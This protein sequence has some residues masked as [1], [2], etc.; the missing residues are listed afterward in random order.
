MKRAGD[1]LTRNAKRSRTNTRAWPARVLRPRRLPK[2]EQPVFWTSRRP[3]RGSAFGDGGRRAVPRGSDPAARRPLPKELRLGNRV[4]PLA[5][6]TSLA[7]LLR[8]PEVNYYSLFEMVKDPSAI[9]DDEV[10]Q[11]VEIQIKYQGYI[12]RQHAEVERSRQHE[13]TPLPPDMDY[14]N[15][16]GLS[17]EARQKLSR[18]KPLTLGKPDALGRHAG[19]GVAAAGAPTPARLIRSPMNWRD[20]CISLSH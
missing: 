14:Q 1:G 9:S 19:G 12:E 15:V 6:D 8:R 4:P 13:N 17:V 11:Q 5:R 18:H 16:H 2:T 20:Y 10:A 7:E 3:S